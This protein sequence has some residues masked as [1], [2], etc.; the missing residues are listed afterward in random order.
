[1]RT[2]EK[3]PPGHVNDWPVH[4]KDAFLALVN[5]TYARIGRGQAEVQAAHEAAR[6][7]GLDGGADHWMTDELL[8][9]VFGVFYVR[10]GDHYADAAGVV[11]FATLADLERLGPD[12][13]AWARKLAE[14]DTDH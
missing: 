1:M 11:R 3:R 2:S 6:E 4:D 8:G 10:S 9:G 12:A 14:A 5:A 13:V 7:V